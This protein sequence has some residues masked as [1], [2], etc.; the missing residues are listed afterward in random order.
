MLLLLLEAEV[1][2]VIVPEAGPE[3]FV[4]L[5]ADMLPSVSVPFPFNETVFIGNVID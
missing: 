1:E 5:Y 3:I 2:L 4:Q